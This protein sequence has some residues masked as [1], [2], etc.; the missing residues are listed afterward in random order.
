[1]RTEAGCK[2]NDPL[3]RCTAERAA[4]TRLEAWREGDR[5]SQDWNRDFEHTNMRL[6]NDPGPLDEFIWFCPNCGQTMIWDALE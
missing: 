2:P 6:Q 3:P 5:H 1:M 4:P